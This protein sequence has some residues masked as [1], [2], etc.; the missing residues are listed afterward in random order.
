MRNSAPVASRPI[1][2]REQFAELTG[3]A[4]DVLLACV[5]G[6]CNSLGLFTA[7]L[8]DPKVRCVGVE[9]RDRL[10]R[11][12]WPGVVGPG[13][14][15]SRPPRSPRPATRVFPVADER[16]QARVPV[17]SAAPRMGAPWSSRRVPGS[18]AIGSFGDSAT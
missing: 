5:G 1:Q 6:G 17:P 4:P 13:P 11:Q 16:W 15:W 3:G 18:R 8:D 2:A 12:R 10:E 14:A 7:F 9:P